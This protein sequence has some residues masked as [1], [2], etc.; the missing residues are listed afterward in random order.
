MIYKDKHDK[1][2]LLLNITPE[3][4]QTDN[5]FYEIIVNAKSDLEVRSIF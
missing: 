5:Y 3:C 4:E 2:K 1:L